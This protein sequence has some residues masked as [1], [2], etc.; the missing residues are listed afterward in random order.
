MNGN[1]HDAFLYELLLRFF[2]LPPHFRIFGVELVAIHKD[3]FFVEKCHVSFY[4]I[5]TDSVSNLSE[6]GLFYPVLLD[7]CANMHRSTLQIFAFLL[8][9]KPRLI[10]INNEAGDTSKRASKARCTRFFSHCPDL[11]PACSV[12]FA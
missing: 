7:I 10:I 9:P 5:F 6:I 12:I 11:Y 2:T 1:K 4:L 8:D 3:L